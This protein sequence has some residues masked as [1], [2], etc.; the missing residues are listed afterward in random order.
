M[1]KTLKQQ[2]HDTL[3]RIQTFN[4]PR[5][6]DNLLKIIEDNIL[7]INKERLTQKRQADLNKKFKMP[8]TY[9]RIEIL[10]ELLEELN[11]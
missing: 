1:T 5:I 4:E 11:Q 7:Q 2:I 9:G 6:P 8:E 3:I 10:T